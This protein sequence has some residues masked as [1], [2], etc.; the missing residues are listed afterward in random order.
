MSE[1]EGPVVRWR[2]M[3]FRNLKKIR[4]NHVV[5]CDSNREGPERGKITQM[6]SDP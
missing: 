1:S 3:V 6:C 2:R 4:N 5:E